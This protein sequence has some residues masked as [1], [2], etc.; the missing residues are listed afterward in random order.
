MISLRTRPAA[1]PDLIE[2]GKRGVIEPAQ[3]RGANYIAEGLP[4]GPSLHS[5]TA[6]L[7]GTPA[8]G[9]IYNGTITATLGAQ[10]RSLPLFIFITPAPGAGLAAYDAWRAVALAGVALDAP[11][12]DADG[13]GLT[14]AVE[15]ACGTPPNDHA[16]SSEPVLSARQ[17]VV[18][19][20]DGML[21]LTVDV[22]ATEIFLGDVVSHR[23]AHDGRPGDEELGDVPDHDREVPQ[24]GLGGANTHYASEQHVD[25][26][27]RG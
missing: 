14:N 27:H 5:Q 17:S 9:G 1:E 11:E 2:Q 20:S 7:S 24:Y 16:V 22:P 21:T 15:F 13:D 6:L 26:R 10:S 8:A 23:V 4:P 25:H 19:N 18:C 3:G 12:Q